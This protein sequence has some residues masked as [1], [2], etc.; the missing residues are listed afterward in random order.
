[1]VK[2]FEDLKAD[3]LSKAELEEGY[4]DDCIENTIKIIKASI[5]CQEEYLF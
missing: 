1:L 5:E 3:I 4:K 2:V